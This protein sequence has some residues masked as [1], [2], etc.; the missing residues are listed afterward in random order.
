MELR[1]LRYKNIYGH[2]CGDLRFDR[3]E[4]F[5]VGINGCG[6]T[7]VLNLIRWLLGPSLPD[8]CTLEHDSIVLDLKH[9]N[10]LYSIQ[11]R[12]TKAKHVLKI[13][14]K[15]KSRVFKPINTTLQT[16]PTAMKENR[17]RQEVMEVY[18]HLSPEPDE[19]PAWSFLLDELPS[20]VFVGLGRDIAMRTALTSHRPMRARQGVIDRQLPVDT[21]TE[22]MRDAF[23]TARRQLVEINDELNRKVLELSF[24][25]VLQYNVRLRSGAAE[26]MRD[27]ITQLKDRF[28]KSSDQGEYSKALSA[29]EVRSAVVKYLE[30]LEAFL[31][32]SGKKDE[33]WVALNQHNFDRAAK[34]FD[35]FEKHEGRA[36]AVQREID[37]FSDAVNCFLNDSEKHIHFNADTG[38]PYFTNVISGTKMSLSELSSGESQIVILLS[39][40]AF[41]AKTGVP[42]IIDEPELSLHVEWQKQLVNAVKR[43]LPPECQTIMATH[44]PEICGSSDVNVQAI[45]VRCKK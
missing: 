29:K 45:S 9:G 7:T 22:L 43:V 41:L 1:R 3:G 13:V 4:N 39:Y 24:S 8:L 34:M 28:T 14:T 6:K 20:P 35:L 30:D 36:Y 15:D 44:S 21:A 31:S 18:R 2:L 5:L 23:N 16:H 33:I 19:V 42:I 10:Y 32:I 38:S 40:F 27:K 25:G 12:I 17:Y 26:G 11:S 37:T